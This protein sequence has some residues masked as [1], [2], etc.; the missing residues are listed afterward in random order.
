MS[1]YLLSWEPRYHQNKNQRFPNIKPSTYYN[2]CMTIQLY[3]KEEYW[4]SSSLAAE[5]ASEAIKANVMER[6]F[7]TFGLLGA[8]VDKKM[9]T[10]RYFEGSVWEMQF[11]INSKQYWNN[12][13]AR[14]IINGEI[15]QAGNRSSIHIV[16]SPSNWIYLPLVI[17]PVAI[18]FNL[19]FPKPAQPGAFALFFVVYFFIIAIGSYRYIRRLKR[20]KEQL[21]TIFDASEAVL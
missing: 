10:Y 8:I 2:P 21:M 6:D 12:P 15:E 20:D 1:N 9:R 7:I 4:L 18:I 17:L 5:E 3:P 19:T 13:R 14:P 16:C 11:K